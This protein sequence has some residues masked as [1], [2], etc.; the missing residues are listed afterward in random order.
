MSNILDCLSS[1][2]EQEC[3]NVK[4]NKMDL[5][6]ADGLMSDTWQASGDLLENFFSLDQGSLNFLEES[7][8][9]FNLEPD[10]VTQ[11]GGLSSSGSDSGLSSD[12]AELDF[13]QE[14]SPY[15]IQNNAEEQPALEPMS[16]E[17]SQ[18]VIIQDG[19]DSS[20]NESIEIHE[21]AIDMVHFEQNVV[22]GFINKSPFQ[23][24]GKGNRKR[25]LSHTPQ[26]PIKPKV[27][28]PAV[29]IP[30]N[31]QKPQLVV[32]AQPQ[33]PLKVTNIQVINQ[34]PTKVYSKPVESVAPQRRVIRVAPMAGNPR[35][36][37]LP[38]TIKDMKDLKSIKIINASDLKNAS[39]IK[40]AAANLLSQRKLQ[41][42]KVESRRDYEYEHGSN[43]CAKSK[44]SSSDDSGSDRSDDDDDPKE[45]KLPDGKNG[46]PRLVLT[47]EE[48]RLLAKE[49]ISLPTSYPLTKQEERE[50]K[51]IRRK[52]RNKISAQDSRK[53]KKEYVDG[54]EDRVKQCT[55]ENQ[56]LMRRI[57]LLQS[58][59][60]TLSAQLKRLQSVLTGVSTNTSSKTAQPATCLLV[61]LLSVA[62]VALPSVRDELRP[63][64]DQPAAAHAH[65][66]AHSHAITRALLSATNKMHLEETVVDDGEVNM[67]ELLTFNRPPLDHDYQLVK[68][69][70]SK[71]PGGYR[72]LPIDEDWPP[73]LKKRMKKLEFDYEDGKDYL[74]IV[75][76]DNYENF[77]KID[78]KL[79]PK[80]FDIG[81]IN[82][83][84]LATTRKLGELLNSFP[85]VPV[86][87]EDLVIEEVDHDARNH[88][89]V[90]SFVVSGNINEY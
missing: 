72:D 77:R 23:S 1:T 70:E 27:Q 49:G 20:S 86:K 36:I 11:T 71:L 78:T 30:V 3:F 90:K 48:R 34:Q 41:D 81:V 19:N 65:A 63:R 15:L 66:H 83:A 67:D 80:M 57:K 54:L 16:P 88:S 37:L 38:V 55:A 39:N 4:S 82:D 5:Y 60:Q 68:S 22:P 56:T 64:N 32:K 2:T 24:P 89:E 42:L 84:L 53:R 62:L 28:K 52:I 74:S 58:Q 43:H 59:N 21:D 47:A 85:P 17:N 69:F 87:N 31:V 18:D 51:R 50:L 29:S 9:D 25:R 14:L 33:K 12:H 10:W 79:E 35:S 46:Y 13:E 6:Q 73:N 75:K 44:I 26:V 7:L 40:L 76:E 8:P 61:L 45:S